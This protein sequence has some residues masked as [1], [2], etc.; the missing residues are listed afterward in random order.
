[1][2][3]PIALTNIDKST[4]MF[5]SGLSIHQSMMHV[6]AVHEVDDSENYTSDGGSVASLTCATK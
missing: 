1:M 3:S 6:S 2:S 4:A 5:G